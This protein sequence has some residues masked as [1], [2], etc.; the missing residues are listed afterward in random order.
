MNVTKYTHACL[1][2]E[3][4]TQKLVIDP[5]S[6]TDSFGDLTGIVAVVITHAHMDH[7]N[8]AH[9]VRIAEANPNVQFFSI[10]EVS[11]QLA[12]PKITAVEPGQTIVTGAFTL[13]F[14]GGKHALIHESIPQ[15]GNIGVMVNDTLYYPGDSFVLPEG[16]SVTALALPVSA[17]WLKIGEAF[18]FLAAVKPRICFPTHNAILSDTGMTIVDAQISTVCATNQVV[19]QSLK[20][21]QTLAL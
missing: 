8:P 13:Q 14:F 20:P 16:K 21:G 15:V 18:D 11:T 5:G 9:L 12:T 7:Y 19:Y 4:N 3:E 6:F 17:P 10:A 1:V 2:L